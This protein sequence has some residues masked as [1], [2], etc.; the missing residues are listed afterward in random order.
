MLVCE[1]GI[2]YGTAKY[3]DGGVRIVADRWTG[4][5]RMCVLS[6]HF[7]LDVSLLLSGNS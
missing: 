6:S 3:N 4:V 2:M 5:R 7:V 1:M